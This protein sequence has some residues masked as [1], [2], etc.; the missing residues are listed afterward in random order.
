MASVYMRVASSLQSGDLELHRVS[1]TPAQDIG[2]SQLQRSILIGGA[3]SKLTEETFISQ[4]TMSLPR[5]GH[6]VIPLASGAFLVRNRQCFY[7]GVVMAAFLLFCQLE[8][9]VGSYIKDC[10][11][12]MSCW[13]EMLVGSSP[14]NSHMTSE[15]D[16]ILE[17]LKETG[18]CTSALVDWRALCR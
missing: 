3:G 1:W 15:R 16:S 11:M 8:Y 7:C 18:E 9:Y 2:V 17:Q 13:C 6:V 14:R 5:R 12:L 10:R 4:P